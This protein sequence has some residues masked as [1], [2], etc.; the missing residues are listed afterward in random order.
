MHLKRNMTYEC[1]LSQSVSDLPRR[2]LND[3]TDG[4]F[5]RKNLMEK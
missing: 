2:V 3:A 4:V 5:E 1:L